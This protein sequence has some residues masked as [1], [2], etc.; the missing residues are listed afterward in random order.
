MKNSYVALILICV[1]GG[2]FS[3]AA[4]AGTPS[5]AER[6]DVCEYSSAE[7]DHPLLNTIGWVMFPVLSYAHGYAATSLA[8][9]PEP[10]TLT[11]V[12]AAIALADLIGRVI[13][14]VAC[15]DEGIRPAGVLGTD[16]LIVYLA[17]SSI[18]GAMLDMVENLPASEALDR[19]RERF[20]ETRG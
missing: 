4:Q 12:G 20:L 11:K 10:T 1:A 5:M 19:A 17:H 18:G 2:T 6:F 8:F 13:P 3:N 14:I 7:R 9:A 15:S 16:D